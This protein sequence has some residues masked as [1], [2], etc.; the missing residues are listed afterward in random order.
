MCAPVAKNPGARLRTLPITHRKL[1]IYAVS[2]HLTKNDGV[3]RSMREASMNCS[4]MIS[5]MH[6][7][8]FMKKERWNKVSYLSCKE[9]G[10]VRKNTYIMA[11]S[12]EEGPQ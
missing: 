4:G 10:E 1:N 2:I 5:R 12:L 7:T 6:Y 9:E 11:G 8:L 3:V